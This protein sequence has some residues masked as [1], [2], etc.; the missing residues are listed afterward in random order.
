MCLLF[1]VSAWSQTVASYNFAESTGTYS[2]L[3]G[4]TTDFTTTDNGVTTTA[5]VIPFTF[6]YNGVNYTTCRISTNG[7]LTMGN[8]TTP[9]SSNYT[10]ISSTTAAY[11]TAISALGWDLNSTVKHQTLGVSPNQTF[12]VEWSN[13]Y[14]YSIGSTENL[15][16]Q[17]RL[18]ETTNKVEIVYGSMT[19]TNTNFSSGGSQVGLKGASADY[20]NVSF[21]NSTLTGFVYTLNWNNLIVANSQSAAVGITAAIGPA[22]GTTLGWTPG[23]CTQVTTAATATGI[24]DAGASVSWTNNAMYASG[25]LVRWRKVNE[26]YTVATW[27]TPVAVAAGSSSYSI[28]GLAASTYYIYSIEGVCSGVSANNFSSV[29]T[30][31]STNAKGLFQTAAPACTGTPAAGTTS[32]PTGACSAVNF[33]LSLTGAT[34]GVAGLT[35][36]WQS[37]ADGLTYINIAS[38]TA[39]ATV[40]QTA[41]TF[42]Q[43][44]VTCTTSALADTSTALNVPMNSVFSCYCAPTYTSGCGTGNDAITNVTLGTLNNTSACAGSPYYTYY[45]AAVVPNVVQGAASTISITF[46]TDGSQYAGVWI[47]YNKDGDFADVGEFVAN[48]T[49]SAGASGTTTLTINVPGTAAIGQTMMRV[50]GGNDSQLAN[51]PCGASSSGF[52]E[53]EDYKINIL[54]LPP[55]PPTPTQSA[56]V[57]TCSSGTDLSVAG[58]PAAGDAWYWQTSAT[59]TSTAVPVSGP[60]TVFVNGTYYVRTYNA[61]NALWSASSSSITITNIPVAPTPPS[62]TAAANPACLSTTISVPAASA[63]VT[64][65]WQ[66]TTAGGTSS[67]MDASTPLNITASGTYYVAAY[68]ASSSCWSNTNGVAVVVDTYIP[69]TPTTTASSV[70]VC[71]AA[72]SAI[73]MAAAP[74]GATSSVVSFGTL[75]QSP[76]TPVMFN[77]TIPAIPAGATITGTQ[78]QITTANAVNGSWRSEI[79][80]ALSGAITLAATQISTAGSGGLISPDPMITTANPAFAGG[81][82]TLTLTETYDDGGASTIDATFA[83]IKLVISYTVPATTINWWDASSAGILQ[84][85]GSPFETVGTTVLP[86]TSTPGTYTFFAQANAGACS[87]SGRLP[88]SVVVNPV[89]LTLNPINVTCNGGSNGSF[90]LGAVSCGVAPFT[91]SVNGG[92]FAAI[93]TNLAAGTYSVIAKDSNGDQSPAISISITQP[94]WTVP[95]ATA[96]AN[97]SVCQNATS[98]L[99]TV[100]PGAVADAQTITVPFNVTG[101]PV[102]TNVAPGNIVTTAILPAIPAGSV[103]TAVT[104]S[105]PGI[106]ATGGSWMSDVKLGFSGAVINTAASG[107]GSTN[108]A[109]TFTYTRT[110]PVGSVNLAGGTVSLLYWDAVSDNA[111]AEATFPTGA[112]AATLTITYT[113]G[114]AINWYDASTGGTLLGT[115]ASLET[116]G[117]SVLPSTATAGVYNFYAESTYS[118]CTSPARTLVTV[119]VNTL[120]TASATSSA[121]LCNGGTSSVVV[122]ATGGSSPYTGTGSFTQ[123]AGTTVYTVTDANSCTATTSVAVTQ[124]TAIM[125]MSSSTPIACN[126]G[127]STVTISATGGTGALSGTGTFTQSAGTTVYTVTDANSCTAT[128]SVVVTQPTA[129]M[130]MSSSTPIACNGGTS[131]VTISAMDGTP[132]YTGTGTFTQSA[133]TTVYTVTDANSCT[134]TASVTVTQP[135]AVMAMSSSTPIA[136]NGGTS[137]VTISAMDGTPGYTGTGTFTQSAGTTVYTVTDANSCTATTSV[138]LTQPATALMVMS[139]STPIACNGGTST[140][141]IS[142]MDGTPGYTGTGTFTQSAGTTVYT[143]T[144][145]N[146][147]T[148]TTSVAVTQPTAIMVMS[149][150]T[151]I[152]CNGGTSTVTVSAMDGTPGYTGTG[153]FTQSAG[154]TV[155]TVTDANSCTATASVAVTQPTAVMVMSSYAPIA[156]NGDSVSVTISAMDGTPGYTGT[157]TFFQSAGTTIYTVTDANSCTGTAS[158][159]LSQ[160]A[161]ITTSQSFNLCAGGSV[162]VGS[163]TYSV[164]GTYTDILTAVNTCDSTVT[165][166]VTINS[167][168]VTTSVAGA[169]ITAIA[170]AGTYQWLNCNAGLAPIAGETG[171]SFTATA[172]GDYA[173][174][175]TDNGCVDTS[176][177]V[178]I[179][180]TMLANTSSVTALS[181]YPNPTNG[182]FNIAISN[183]NFSELVISIV[184]IQGKEVFSSSEK[185]VSG[186]YNKQINLEELSKGLY[187]I[188]MNTAVEVKIQKLIIQ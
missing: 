106:T 4:A 72:T 144:D 173:V 172:N 152:A 7:F 39:T 11:N 161:A 44:I 94:S 6:V 53:T 74:S 50:R 139:S 170:S 75:L 181:V 136:C 69:A 84:G 108:A 163:N 132:G 13:A 25:Y 59:G 23:T 81:A 150:S 87:S 178:N 12:V 127:T 33:T 51:T 149:S 48:N 77:A 91:Y 68:D 138:T 85:A 109:G 82:V 121:I 137:T 26:D 187:Y 47:D 116:V 130:A 101:Q 119:T 63:P 174:E 117:T 70:I 167:I 55:T 157:G 100:V 52:G 129:V 107:T 28:T 35:Y 79:R 58:T 102:E 41:A 156:C 160:P 83:E 113:P 171:Q 148:V 184:D 188:K 64:Y 125:V 62:P 86:N 122:S 20:N 67:A 183:A 36:Q 142:A 89:L 16:F 80:V 124:P 155:Y 90:A 1:S 8:A 153:T 115:S 164:A 158:V 168:N 42:Y 10:P 18:S 37:S 99:V 120:P 38:T 97:V 22:S 46:G 145:A 166:T 49:T 134:A 175:I 73:I 2:S 45:S 135:T 182:I 3:A 93:P 179:N 103:I 60:Y 32:G 61:T 176:A 76:G 162:T 56:T 159:V 88:V 154:T 118:G 9:S 19:T 5:V 30:T 151:P 54:A 14:R 65:Y 24:T 110:L 180:A 104:F 98:A 96:G 128:A 140:V 177:C 92:A 27:T 57:P 147:C 43:C 169:T 114:S 185:N 78:L 131:T 31:N 17:I 71:Q 34:T 29:T 126:G 111:A 133:G 40:S 146:S 123:S 143:V 165:T 186:A 105:Y 15:N 95:N 21:T 141:T 112:S 66:G